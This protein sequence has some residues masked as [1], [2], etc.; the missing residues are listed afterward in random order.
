MAISPPS[1]ILLDVANAADP[2]KGPRGDQRVWRHSPPIR[3]HK[4]PNSQPPLKRAK[5]DLGS[6]AVQ[7]SDPGSRPTV[8]TN[9]GPSSGSVKRIASHGT[10]E[11]LYK[12]RGGSFD[13]LRR[14]DA[15]EKTTSCS[16]TRIPPASTA[17]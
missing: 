8:A 9:A 17:R 2:A 6:S 3:A 14:V 1:D 13:E 12:V 4:T 10:T 11:R 16:A 7:A 5:S 15:A